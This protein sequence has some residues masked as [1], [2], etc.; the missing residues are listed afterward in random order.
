M[1]CGKGKSEGEEYEGEQKDGMPHGQGTEIKLME[2]H[3]Q[4]NSQV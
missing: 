1:I 4:G 3:M 2:V